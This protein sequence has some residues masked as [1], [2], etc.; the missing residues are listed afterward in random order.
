MKIAVTDANI[1]I[2]LFYLKQTHHLFSIS[3]E[4]F[5]TQR[6]I[7]ELNE[8]LEEIQTFIESGHL[9][10]EIIS[11]EDLANMLPMRNSSRLSESD[12]SVLCIAQRIGAIVLSGDDLV[13]KTCHF[14]KIEIHGILWCLDQFVDKKCI[15]K[16]EACN[17][18][19]DLMNYNSRLPVENCKDYIINKWGGKF[20]EDEKNE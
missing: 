18:L 7:N 2:D 3:F 10:V 20:S 13:R 12:I 19:K 6:V 9:L 17:S 5:T 1:F 15:S 16:Q 4:I 11:D 8:E 14:H